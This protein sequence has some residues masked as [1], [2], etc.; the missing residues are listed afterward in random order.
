MTPRTV[1]GAPFKVSARVYE[2]DSGIGAKWESVGHRERTI[3]GPGSY[4]L[5]FN[6]AEGHVE[7]HFR[8]MES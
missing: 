6:H 1:Y 4:M 8:V 7:V 5:E 3:N 2:H